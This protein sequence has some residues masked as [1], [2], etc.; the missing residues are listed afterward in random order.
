LSE[1]WKIVREFSDAAMS[2]SD[3]SRPQYLAMLAAAA[4]REFD[5]L[6][7]DDFFVAPH[8]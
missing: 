4:K 2:G 7:V 5:V 8:A 3:S 1:G 6:V